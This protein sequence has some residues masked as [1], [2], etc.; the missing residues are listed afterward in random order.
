MYGSTATILM[1][2]AIVLIYMLP[3]FIAF[4]REH[5]RRQDV[6]VINI[7]FGWTLIGWIGAFLWAALAETPD[8]LA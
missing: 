7:L 2:M 8:E 4:G 3:T 1:L 6:A 5:P